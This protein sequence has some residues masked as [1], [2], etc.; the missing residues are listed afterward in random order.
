MRSS[1]WSLNAAALSLL[2]AEHAAAVSFPNA[3]SGQGFISVPVGT[4][5][6]PKKQPASN[7]KRDAFLTQLQNQDFFYTTEV[8]IGNPGQTVTVLVD[9]GSSELWVNPDCSTASTS[10]QE[11]QCES[12]GQYDPSASRDAQGPFGSERID[13]GDP[14]DPSTLTSVNIR[15]YR[16]DLAFGNA[17]ITNQTFGVVSSSE[18]QSQ[19]IMGLAPDLFGGFD[20]TDDPYSLILN[21]MF[22]Q[23]IINSRAFAMDLRHS[24]SET[25]AVIYGGFDRNKFIGELAARP[26]IRGDEGEFR[27]ATRLTQV[28]ITDDR[29]R[30]SSFVLGEQ[31]TN[32]MI[33]S[34]TTLTRLHPAVITPI[35]DALGAV[36]DGQSGYYV[37]CETRDL[38]G[39]IDFYFGPKKVRVPLRDF[40]IDVGDPYICYV[41]VAATTGQQILGDSVM[42]AGYFVFDWDN[43]EVHIA[44]AANCGDADIVTIGTGTDAVPSSTGNCD[45]SLAAFTQAP[46]PTSEATSMITTTFVITSCGPLAPSCETGQVVTET[47]AASDGAPSGGSNGDNNDG[48][49][50]GGDSAGTRSEALAVMAVVFGLTAGAFNIWY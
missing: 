2:A 35:I 44:Q 34:G 12:F 11:A 47:L 26:I 29:N 28:G 40:I 23:G 49:G 13:Y 10:D 43:E 14:T 15:Y 20:I 46:T 50:G 31:D 48:N 32:V 7:S 22:E 36:S 3:R 5:D 1:S 19:G 38:P 18:G 17:R 16:D 6:R 30:N 41:G 8:V 24:E 37:P 25:G 33:D 42:R 27:L 4:V 9:T 21:T 45:P 39:S